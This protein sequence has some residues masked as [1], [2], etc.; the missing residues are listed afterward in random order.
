MSSYYTFLNVKRFIRHKT[1][2]MFF[3]GGQWQPDVDLAQNFN[4]LAEAIQVAIKY[5]LVGSEVILQ[6]ADS[7]N[8]AMD[9]RLD[10]LTESHPSGPLPSQ[11]GL[12]D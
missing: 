8:P 12:A 6:I 1:T 9:V 2:G 5:H 4:T 11:P 10:L 7:P 3:A